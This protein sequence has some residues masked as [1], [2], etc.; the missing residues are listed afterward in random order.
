MKNVPLALSVG[1]L[2][3]VW[4]YAA[5]TLGL[6]AWA[7]FVSW[8][9]FF[10]AG[11]DG[12][13]IMKAWVPLMA[14]VFFGYVSLYGGTPI[15]ISVA[16]GVSAAILV[17]LTAIPAFALA[18]AAFGAFAVFFAYAFGFSNNNPFDFNNVVQVVIALTCGVAVGYV[19][20]AL[21][22]MFAGSKA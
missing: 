6:P 16:V 8:A 15:G 2:A 17:L 20:T 18:P 3:I 22:A 10:V 13:A 12:K 9:F 19:S 11:G 21:P 7:G 1:G 14:G 5:I 4:T